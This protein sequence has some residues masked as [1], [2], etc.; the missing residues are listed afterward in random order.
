MQRRDG[1]ACLIVKLLAEG[2]L[3]ESFGSRPSLLRVSATLALDLLTMAPHLTLVELDFMQTL[4]DQGKEPMQIHA[5]LKRRRDRQG[6]DTPCLSRFRQALRGLTYKRGR[7]ETRGRKVKYSRRWVNK[8]NTTRKHLLKKAQGER[9]V[10]WDD[11]RRAARAPTGDRRT[12]ARSFRREGIL[13]AARRP[14]LKPAR[15]KEQAQARVDH[16]RAWGRKSPS[17]FVDTVD[18]IID[19]KQFDIPTSARAR[20][21]LAS[22]RVRFH[23]RTPGEGSQPEMTKPGR[24]KNKMNTGAVA[25]VCAGINN[26]RVVMWEYL[27]SRWN[28]DEAAKLYRGAVIKTLR[29][30][31]GHKA[32]YML[33]EDNDPAGYKSSKGVAAKADLGIKAVPSPP[34]SPDLNPLDYFVWEEIER[35]MLV[36][37]PRNVET[38]AAYKKRLRL[39]A[40]R[41]PRNGVTR[42]VRAMP[43]RMRAVVEAKG[44]NIASDLL[45]WTAERRRTRAG[46]GKKEWASLQVRILSVPP[47]ANA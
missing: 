9:E 46:A 4:E 19:N 37:A 47:L 8:L 29:K 43:K 23:L 32:R 21:H 40:L 38:V 17:Y 13:V 41:L 35:R 11:V 2:Q 7:K 28:G 5:A 15:T 20:A 44:Y 6:I 34:Y 12:V 10:R 31:R 14:R 26:G 1:T 18:L 25:K 33:F 27:P 3:L 36:N 45:S 42:A 30:H 39:T 22:Q 16:C 24:K